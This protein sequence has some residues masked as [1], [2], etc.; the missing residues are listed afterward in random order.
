MICGF[1]LLE[2]VSM[3]IFKNSFIVLTVK[4][5]LEL[6]IHTG[7]E[8]IQ[9]DAKEKVCGMLVIACLLCYLIPLIGGLFIAATSGVSGELFK[10]VTIGLFTVFCTFVFYNLNRRFVV[11]K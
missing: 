2:I 1:V 11:N 10:C 9:G 4:C 5:L 8:V 7:R 6:I 3:L